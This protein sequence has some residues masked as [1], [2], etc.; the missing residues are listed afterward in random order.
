MAVDDDD[1]GGGY[2]HWYVVDDHSQLV[3]EVDH[4]SCQ[5]D[6]HGDTH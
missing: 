5:V 6:N 4:N 2:I 1:D 3:D